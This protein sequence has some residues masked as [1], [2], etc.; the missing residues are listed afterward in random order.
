MKVFNGRKR[1]DNIQKRKANDSFQ[2]AKD[3]R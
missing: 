2:R 3:K 1:N